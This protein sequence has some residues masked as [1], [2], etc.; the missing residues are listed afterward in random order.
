MW[1]TS[2]NWAFQTF[3][4]GKYYYR[5]NIWNSGDSGAGSQSVWAQSSRCWGA[6]AN[7]ANNS[8]MVKS[9]PQFVRGW[10]VGDGFKSEAPNHGLGIRVDQLQQATIHW[11]MQT[12]TSGGRFMALWDIYFHDKPNPGGEKAQTSLMIFQRILDDGSLYSGLV[13]TMPVLTIDG[14][15]FGYEVGTAFWATGKVLVLHML[16]RNGL[17]FGQDSMTLDL[18]KLI[19]ALRDMGHISG[20]NDY[21]TSIQAGWEIIA[22]GSYTTTDYWTAIQ[23][24]SAP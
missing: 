2:S 10:A 21:L 19:D 1:S 23:S 9:Y 15:S 17:N 24:E 18:K 3:D 7:H 6:I 8:G 12:P 16:P 11:S 13:P 20:T 14:M 5:N 22:G 4:G